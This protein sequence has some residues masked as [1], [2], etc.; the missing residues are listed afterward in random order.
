[1]TTNKLLTSVIA[2]HMRTPA[3]S[4]VSRLTRSHLYTALHMAG[5]GT[6]ARAAGQCMEE[7]VSAFI[8]MCDRA[9]E[10]RLFAA[11]HAHRAYLAANPMVRP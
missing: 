2:Q 11:Q 6:L 9:R 1:M 3:D 10:A 7:R 4:G 8:T 5:L